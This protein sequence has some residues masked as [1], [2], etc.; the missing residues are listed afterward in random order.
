MQFEEEG[1]GV[2]ES[3]SYIGFVWQSFAS[4]GAT[5]VASVRSC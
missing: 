1:L 5:E 4:G 2:G 3:M